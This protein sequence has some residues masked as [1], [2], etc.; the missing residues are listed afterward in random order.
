[1]A[2][3]VYTELELNDLFNLNLR[4]DIAK[5]RDIAL[6]KKAWHGVPTMPLIDARSWS[7]REIDED[8]LIWRAR[9]VQGRLREMPIEIFPEELIV[10]RPE[11]RPPNPDEVHAINESQPVLSQ[12]PP[13]PG[14]DAGHFHPDFDKL[15]TLG[16]QGIIDEIKSRV[17][18]TDLVPPSNGRT[19]D[20]EKRTF[21]RACEMAIQGFSEYAVRVAGKCSE[22]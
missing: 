15:L 12:I 8:W 10:G 22:L 17:N 20:E 2:H 13:F 1:M 14:G 16:I 6:K 5:L 11:M 7:R 3:N 9:R 4:T 18:A 19:D 21:Y